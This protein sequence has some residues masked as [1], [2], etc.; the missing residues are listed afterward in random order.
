MKYRTT[1]KISTKKE[2]MES[3]ARWAKFKAGFKPASEVDLDDL[4]DYK[5]E[6][7]TS[8]NASLQNELTSVMQTLK[9]IADRATKALYFGLGMRN[10]R[11]F[12]SLSADP[13]NLLE[14]ISCFKTVK[15][16]TEAAASAAD[17]ALYW[18]GG[19][20]V[21]SECRLCEN[22]YMVYVLEGEREPP[23]AWFEMSR[24]LRLHIS[25]WDNVADDEA[26]Q[27]EPDPSH[28]SRWTIAIDKNN[29]EFM[30]KLNHI[31]AALPEIS[32]SMKNWTD[33][34]VEQIIDEENSE[35]FTPG[36]HEDYSSDFE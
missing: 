12:F 15:Y 7:M 1:L 5:H 2:R 3:A 8:L 6:S 23:E 30:S 9:T 25:K 33:W 32:I 26:P 16:D 28:Y 20:T 27:A 17:S 35:E 21:I 4:S 11:T 36:Y 19:G 18:P 14:T 10:C 31:K 29:A 34:V 13:F 24:Q 22:G